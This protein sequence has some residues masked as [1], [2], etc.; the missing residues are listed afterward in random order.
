MPPRR[1]GQQQATP[2]RPVHL[3]GLL[4]PQTRPV[5]VLRGVGSLL[6]A[7]PL[8][9][10]PLLTPSHAQHFPSLAS[11]GEEPARPQGQ[12]CPQHLP[13]PQRCCRIQ[14]T[15]AQGRSCNQAPI[16]RDPHGRGWR[17]QGSHAQALEADAACP[18][19]C[20]RPL[21]TTPVTLAVSDHRRPG[22]GVGTAGSLG[23]QCPG[24][25]PPQPSHFPMVGTAP[26]CCGLGL[27]GTECICPQR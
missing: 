26:E 16:S 7:T 19:P 5:C 15:G 20:L 8:H 6:L 11:G 12:P 24:A 17:G 27:R 10:L 4:S 18:R 23:S 1:P 2:A 25:Q 22:L 9:P 14:C 13:R 3:P 21:P